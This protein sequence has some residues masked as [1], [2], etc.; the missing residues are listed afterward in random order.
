M[1]NEKLHNIR[2]SLAHLL[3]SAVLEKYPHAKL[4][5]GPV[6]ETGFYYDFDFSGGPTPNADDL[7]DLEKRIKHLVKQ[8]LDFSGNEVSVSEAK[9]IF[10]EAPYKL[11]LIEEF[12][13]DG[14]KLT[15]YTVGKFLDLCRGGHVDNTKEINADAFKLD[16]LAGAYWRGDEKNKMLTRIY[17]LA[18]ENKESLDAHLKQKEEAQKRDHRRLGKELDLFTFSE[19]IGPGLPLFTPKGTAMRDAIIEKIQSIQK[20]FGYQKVTIPH[21][22]K[23]D[24]YEKSGH[25]T[26]FGE[27]LFKV[28]GAS[29]TEFVMKPM[30]C[31]HHTQIFASKQR[32]YKD[33]PIRYA[34]TT[35]VYRDEQAGELLGLSRVRSI[36]QDDGHV[37]CAVEQIEQEINNVV[38]VI[39]QFY[40]ALCMFNEGDFWVRV[41][42]RDKKEKEK[43]L[44]K[45]ENWNRAE[46]ILED[47]V[48]KKGLPYKKVDGEAA[49]YGPKLDFMFKD[50]IG[51][52]WQL[53]TA[54]L[55]FVMP[56]RFG[57]EFT[58]EKGEKEAP[59]MIHRA[60]AG[61]LER[62]LS[63]I[64][65]HFGG[66]FP[67]WLSPVQVKVISIAEAHKE[68]AKDVFEKLRD[69]DIRV[70][71]DDSDESLG[72]KIR[73]GKLEKVPYMLVLGGEELEQK[74]VMVESRD[75]GKIGQKTL[76]EFIELIK[77]K[78]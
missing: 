10:K 70:E 65:E 31:P 36:S 51:R 33:L 6:I 72:K 43:Y 64:I 75:E 53:A 73:Q 50:A 71:L 26:K 16:K 67:V 39:E 66:A 63:V 21:I 30:N 23:K 17:G 32:S 14:K 3:A 61:S 41:S 74:K 57:L 20:N 29:N 13:G 1:E 78:N 4:A 62:F 69:I 58:N 54:Q 27:E 37:F 68:Y 60:I 12:S 34:E 56:E 9:E 5:I 45:E 46:D 2:H 15:T 28:K 55:D 19:L 25:W 76:E 11:E 24:L 47:I 59:V 22:T 38:S 77:S 44:G 48:K 42:A 18:F 7:K 52:E 40:T 49:F 35:M 8:T